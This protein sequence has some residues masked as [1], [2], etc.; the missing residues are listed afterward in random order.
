MP[1]PKNYSYWLCFLLFVLIAPCLKAQSHFALPPYLDDI[2]SDLSAWFY[3]ALP[4]PEGQEDSLMFIRRRYRDQMTESWT[5]V[6]SVGYHYDELGRLEENRIWHWNMGQW[7]VHAQLYFFYEN[8]ELTEIRKETAAAPADGDYKILYTNN[9]EEQTRTYTLEYWEEGAWQPRTRLMYQYDSLTGLLSSILIQE[10]FSS[11]EYTNFLRIL[12]PEYN[13]EGQNTERYDE[14]WSEDDQLWFNVNRTVS[15][16][17]SSGQLELKRLQVLDVTHWQDVHLY[18]Y[19][20]DAEGHLA[21][22]R[23]RVR[24]GD[25][26]WYHDLRESY[27]YEADQI[28]QH[29][30]QYG[31]EGEEGWVND[32]Q[33]LYTYDEQQRPETEVQQIWDWEENSWMQEYRL[34]YHYELLDVATTAAAVAARRFKLAPNPAQEGLWLEW[35]QPIS[36]NDPV[37]IQILDSAGRMLQSSRQASS[38]QRIFIDVSLLP[39]GFYVLNVQIR[40]QRSSQK[41]VIQR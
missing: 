21:E 11:Q 31:L 7:T 10:A 28:Q 1:I 35:Q 22:F 5:T 6:D 9:T 16:Y 39:A 37:S 2:P 41:L 29:L 19:E 12:Y 23:R 24:L 25:E 18:F 33:F 3:A 38:N 34:D 8:D 20:Y 13:I 17:D 15:E 4:Y 32:E 40:D 36:P 30:L 27:T 26:T 14:Y